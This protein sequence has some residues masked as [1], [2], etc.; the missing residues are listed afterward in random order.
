MI[1]V[2]LCMICRDNHD[3][4]GA[5][6]DDVRAAGITEMVVCD[7]GSVDDTIEIAKSKGA[8]VIEREW[9]DDFAWAKNEALK[10]ALQDWCFILDSDD[11]ISNPAELRKFLE[12]DLPR[13]PET[14]HAIQMDVSVGIAEKMTTV[15]QTKF[16]RKSAGLY[17]RY[18][19]HEN[20][21]TEGHEIY[22]FRD[23][24]INHH[25]AFDASHNERNMRILLKHYNDL[26]FEFEPQEFQQHIRLNLGREYLGTA[27]RKQ[28]CKMF[29]EFFVHATPEQ[30]RAYWAWYYYAVAT[31]KGKKR[32]DRFNRCAAC[33][34]TRA[35]AW[36]EIGRVLMDMKLWRQA[37]VPLQRAMHCPYPEDGIAYPPDYSWRPL[38]LIAACCGELGAQSQAWEFARAAQTKGCPPELVPQHA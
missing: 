30:N 38:I 35:E 9:R 12:E 25:N 20:V 14:T 36:V 27:Q 29:A 17:F 3:T 37:L 32:L 24:T 13:L 28:A 23:V 5:V 6:L 1:P 15:T 10:E 2:T 34:P 4:I 8:R 19:I 31:E 18:P 22:Y 26:T 21:N 7:T 11:R 33:D 16:L